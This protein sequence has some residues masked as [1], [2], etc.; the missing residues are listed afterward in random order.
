VLVGYF[1]EQA[2]LN[3]MPL[4]LHLDKVAIRRRYRSQQDDRTCHPF[5]SDGAD[6]NAIAVS[7][8]RHDED[9]PAFGK[10]CVVEWAVRLVDSLRNIE[11]NSLK[12]MFK[13]FKYTRR[14]ICRAG[15]VLR[16]GGLDGCAFAIV[17]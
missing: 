9:H 1:S 10:T 13:R 7:H 8:V 3:P 4:A 2:G 12:V 17:S 11:P 6:F 15:W 14:A 16:D 5:A